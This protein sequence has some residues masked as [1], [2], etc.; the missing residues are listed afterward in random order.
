MHQKQYCFLN[1]TQVVEI[2]LENTFGYPWI[3][4]FFLKFAQEVVPLGE[5]HFRRWNFED[6]DLKWKFPIPMKVPIPTPNPKRFSLILK[7]SLKLV[8]YKQNAKPDC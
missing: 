3:K 5:V 6:S 4:L 8:F 1:T 7:G 2:S